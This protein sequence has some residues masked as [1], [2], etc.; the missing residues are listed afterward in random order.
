MQTYSSTEEHYYNTARCHQGLHRLQLNMA[1]YGCPQN[2]SAQSPPEYTP[3]LYPKCVLNNS[4]THN[5]NSV[6][7]RELQ[8][9][10]QWVMIWITIDT[11]GHTWLAS[12]TIATGKVQKPKEEQ[13]LLPA[14]SIR[15]VKHRDLNALVPNNLFFALPLINKSDLLGRNSQSLTKKFKCA[16]LL[17]HSN[18]QKYVDFHIGTI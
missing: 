8:C 6:K 16:P 7:K 11:L 2:K 17:H 13:R 18:G 3:K 1:H 5:R 14:K 10:F 12:Q 15:S 9:G 4:T